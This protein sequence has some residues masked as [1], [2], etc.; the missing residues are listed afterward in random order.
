M[1]TLICDD[2]AV[3]MDMLRYHVQKYLREHF[4]QSE[5]T[6][7]TD[8]MQIWNGEER[9]DIAFLDI[10]MDG[11]DGI[12]L[13]KKLRERNSKLILFFVTNY[14][15]YQDEA[16]DLRAFR[17]YEKPFDADRLYSGLDKAME[18]LDSTYLDVI[19]AS[20][21]SHCRIAA[22]DICYVTRE[23]RKVILVTKENR[24]YTSDDFDDC[25]QRLP[26]TFFYTVHKSFHVNLHSI[27]R[28]GYTELFLMDG[29]RIPVSPRK[30][31]AFH[32]FW[33]EYLKRH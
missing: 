20:N 24:Y 14:D 6:A 12:T 19:I 11:I 17:F 31:A 32:K 3:F 4:I 22:D 26:Q 18:Y 7:V 29:T 1:K 21:G 9:F 27:R 10:Q 5:V 23:N 33:F 25:C 13:A 16:M 30:Q 15:E 2:D 8:P 28:Y